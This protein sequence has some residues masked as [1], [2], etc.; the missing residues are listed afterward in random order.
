MI[1][2]GEVLETHI[3]HIGWCVAQVARL[4]GG[5]LPTTALYALKAKA[6]EDRGP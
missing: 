3:S 5:P 6:A 4:F 2:V 1:Y